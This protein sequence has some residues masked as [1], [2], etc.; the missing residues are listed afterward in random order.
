[1]KI[2][3]P[4]ADEKHE[5]LIDEIYSFSFPPPSRCRLLN[6]RKIHH[7]FDTRSE[8]VQVPRVSKRDDVN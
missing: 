6:V 4:R 7:T 2:F 8:Y 3:S 1:M 5:E